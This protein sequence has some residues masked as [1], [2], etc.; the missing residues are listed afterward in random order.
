M[1][2]RIVS[3][4]LAIASALFFSS[5][6]GDDGNTLGEGGGGKGGGPGPT[7]VASAAT[8]AACSDGKDDDCD[9][10]PDCLDPDCDGQTCGSGGEST[11]TAGA[12]LAPI[13][14]C[15][16]P[17]LPRI[18]N[19]QVTVHGTTAKL[20]FEPV[21]GA[22]DYRVYARPT[23]NCSIRVWRTRCIA[24]EATFPVSGVTSRAAR[25]LVPT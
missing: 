18:D 24:A 11:C 23:E 15:E 13:A 25:T 14:G 17:E 16:L 22:K 2:T 10:Y 6:C 5:G 20:A 8:E 3:S 21:P 1:R 9:G 7:C 19:V 4:A 12:C